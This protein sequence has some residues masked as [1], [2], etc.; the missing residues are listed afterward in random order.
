VH[1]QS[2]AGNYV[3][4]NSLNVGVS[5]DIY[6]YANV[7]SHVIQ[8]STG[9]GGGGGGLGGGGSSTHSTGGSTFGGHG[10]KF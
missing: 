6:L 2:N 1:K 5:R 10:G 4:D 8:R 3:R 9:S 7:T